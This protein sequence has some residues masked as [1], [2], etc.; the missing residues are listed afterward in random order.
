MLSERAQRQVD[1]LLDEAEAAIGKKDW[2]LVAENARA[3]L[4][5][6]PD[7]ADA[8]TFLAAADRAL[9]GSAGERP[10]AT[11]SRRPGGRAGGRRNRK[12]C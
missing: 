9:A 1:R 10:D 12:C 5:L 3:V 6:D 4:A 8:Q 2:E 11:G 7:N